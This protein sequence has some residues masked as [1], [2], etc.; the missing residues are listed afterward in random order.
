M[1]APNSLDETWSTK[2]SP[3]IRK[4]K[5]VSWSS[6]RSKAVGVA[7]SHVNNSSGAK[8]GTVWGQADQ[9]RAPLTPSPTSALCSL[10]LTCTAALLLVPV[11]FLSIFRHPASMMLYNAQ[12]YCFSVMYQWLFPD[13]NWYLRPV[14]YAYLCPLMYKYLCPVMYWYLCPAMY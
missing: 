1:K 8:S 10:S 4:S 11:S 6:S 13:K 9:H 7:L 2:I 14:M 12:L 5:H 3:A